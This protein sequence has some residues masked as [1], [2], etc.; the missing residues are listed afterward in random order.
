MTRQ[1]ALL[2]CFL[3][4]A[5][6]F[7]VVVPSIA[8]PDDYYVDGNTGND[9]GTGASEDPWKTIVHA[10]RQAKGTDTINVRYARYD[11]S[12]S[13]CP[14]PKRNISLI[15]I[16]AGNARPIICSRSPNTHTISLTNYRGTIKGLEIT[17]ASHANGINCNA[18]DGGINDAQIMD[19]EL[20][21]NNLGVHVT[22]GGSEDDCSPHICR[23]IIYSNTSRGIGNMEYS[24][25]TIEANYIYEN[26][27]GSEGDGGIGNCNNSAAS[28]ISNTVYNN[29]L[30]GISIRDHANPRIINNT[31][32]G[33]NAAAFSSGGIKVSQNM[34]ISSVV[35][36]NNIIT[37]N[38]CGL[39]SQS[40]QY[41]SGNDYNDVWNNS[42]D[43]VGFTKGVNDISC[44]PLFADFG[45]GD[46]HLQQGSPCIDAGTSEGAPDADIDGDSR[47]QGAGYDMGAGEYSDNGSLPTGYFATSDLWIGAVIN[48]DEKE[49]IEAVWQKGGE[50][51]TSRG[52]TVIWGHFYASPSDVTWGSEDNPDLFV[53]IWFDVS[54]RVDVNFFHVSVPDIVVYSDYPYDGVLDE[55]GTTTMSRRYIRQY[56]EAGQSYSDENY[57]D[58][59]PLPGYF[60]SGYPFGYSTINDLRIGAVINTLEKGPVDAI[61][62]LGG[63]D[64]TARG[65]EVVWGHFYASPS[66]VTW[67]SEDNPDLFVK[68]W[69]DVSGR[70][71]VNYFHVSVPDIEVYSDIPDDGTY[72]QKGTTIMDDRYIRHEYWR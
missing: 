48:T 29:N 28:I 43:Y 22:T 72:D 19:C 26:G 65:D 9:A 7:A 20:Y 5:I 16:A 13:F 51:T 2:R 10:I 33:H 70:V 63:Q 53:K 66:D 27:S 59:N 3:S 21:G 24:S 56:Y 49:P 69:F 52:D 46:F 61:W 57:E 12:L 36:L 45:K 15:G 44:D 67:G 55:Q 18:K 8:Y 23:N 1:I 31:I 39:R 32:S 54:G 6:L 37:N 41:C 62:R 4:L 17:G 68:I 47:P 25:A 71:D 50:D 14:R 40:C 60:P 38:K 30:G 35:I 42:D 58:G 11:E 64:T 34:G